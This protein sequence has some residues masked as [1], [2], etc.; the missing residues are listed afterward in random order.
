MKGANPVAPAGRHSSQSGALLDRAV[1]PV[2]DTPP[3]PAL[4][5]VV[6]P[7]APAAGRAPDADAVL[8]V[9]PVLEPPGIV[10][11]WGVTAA[12]LAALVVAGRV[13]AP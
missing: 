2:A 13:T 7:P 10:A 11:V 6:L 12:A 5:D 4:T 8:V 1:V 9:D 3:E